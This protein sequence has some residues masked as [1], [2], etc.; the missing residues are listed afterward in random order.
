[1]D[2]GIMERMRDRSGD[3]TKR[4]LSNLVEE[5]VIV[6]TG[7][8]DAN[9]PSQRFIKRQWP[10]DGNE[11]WNTETCHVVVTTPVCVA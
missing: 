8:K 4:L 5:S 3:M 2:F 6:H 7:L 11:L 10:L 1:M 9:P